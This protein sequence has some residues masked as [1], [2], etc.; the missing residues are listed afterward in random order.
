MLSGVDIRNYGSGN[1]GATNT[2]RVMGKGP[3]IA[4]FIFDIGKGLLAVWL[5]RWFA[6]DAYWV[7]VVCGIA[8]I[9]GHN[10]PVWFRF[11]G[12]KGIAT[13]VGMFIALAFIPIL[14]AGIAAIIIIILTRYVSLGS[15]LLTVFFPIFVFWMDYPSE[16]LWGSL[17]VLIFAWVKH[18]KNIYKLLH[19]TE[20][21]L[22][23]KSV[24]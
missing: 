16:L 1:A 6:P 14:F 4:V 9:A 5:A 7:S 15:L 20:N 17:V 21:K 23:A 22:G 2:L 24:H 13:M 19:G 18:R 8:V 12:G 10:W 3:A 11:R